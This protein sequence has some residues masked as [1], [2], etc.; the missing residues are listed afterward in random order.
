MRFGLRLAATAA[1]GMCALG[2]I[3]QAFAATL[4][5]TTSWYADSSGTAQLGSAS[6]GTTTTVSATN[7][8]T[9]GQQVSNVAGHKFTDSSLYGFNDAYAF[10]L[11]GEAAVNS[12]TATMNLG[13][14]LDI[15]NLQVRLYRYDGSAPVPLALTG[16]P[17]GGSA[18]VINAWTPMPVGTGWATV[19]SATNL[20]AGNY[21]L[22]VRGVGAGSA[23]GT[24]AGVL[25]V[26]PVP[27]PVIAALPLLLSGLG[28]LGA[29]G[30][31]RQRLIGVKN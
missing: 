29:G 21:V 8:Y 4:S 3:P 19:F 11:T 30:L 9:Y 16:L 14:L 15:Q 26:G 10:S 24:Y 13:S 20:L 12:I 22:E 1:M 6:T 27:V 7:G 31:L 17:A 18:P 23:G 5:L 28:I 2:A 25:Q